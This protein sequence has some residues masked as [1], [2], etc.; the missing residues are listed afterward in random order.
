MV[1]E[2]VQSALGFTVGDIVRISCECE[3]AR[4][5]RLM[6]GNVMLDWPWRTI[7]P[8]CRR[9]RWDGT[10][11]LPRDP[12][13]YDGGNSP[14]STDPDVQE[15]G[16][17]DVCQ[18]GVEPTEVRI[19]GIRRFDPPAALGWLP[20]TDVAL[21]MCFLGVEDDP[22]GGFTIYLPSAEPFVIEHLDTTRAS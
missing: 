4:V 22:E 16:P 15:L 20:H 14:W 9:F 18:V 3:E 1:G 2:Q 17:G 6:G 11:G 8:D 12:D 10:V 21:G 5:A 7:D 19:V 13:H